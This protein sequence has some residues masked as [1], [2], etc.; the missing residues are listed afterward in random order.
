[1]FNQYNSIR[2]HRS[3]TNIGLLTS[4]Y[5]SESIRYNTYLLVTGIVKLSP[6]LEP[7]RRDSHPLL[8]RHPASKFLLNIRSV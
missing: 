7:P 6:L 4:H 3:K 1:M 5:S 2:R 8:T